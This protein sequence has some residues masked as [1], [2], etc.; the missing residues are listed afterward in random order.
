MSIK[1]E[2]A[3]KLEQ[4]RINLPDSSNDRYIIEDYDLK[5]PFSSFLPG[6]AGLEGVPM[7]CYYTNRGQAVSSF[8]TNGKQTPFLEF[9]P[10]DQAYRDTSTLGFRTFI[11]FSN[12]DFFEAFGPRK[13]RNIL[14]RFLSIGPA[15]I[16]LTEETDLLRITVQYAILP[17]ETFPGLLRSVVFENISNS[18][19]EMEILDGPG[20]IV[21]YGINDGALKGMSTTAAAWIE[22]D[23]SN[24]EIPLFK[25]RASMEDTMKV[26]SLDGANFLLAALSSDSE[27]RL[28]KPIVDPATVF[29]SDN[30]FSDPVIFRLEGLYGVFSQ[31]QVVLGRY[32]SGF[33]GAPV[34][35]NPDESVSLQVLAGSLKDEQLPISDL[36]GFVTDGIFRR[37]VNESRE[38][39]SR[40]MTNFSMKSSNPKLDSYTR[41]TG[42]DNLLRGGFPVI[43]GK[44]KPEVFHVYSRKHGDMERDYNDFSIPPQFF[45]AGFGNFRDINQNRRMDIMLNPGIGSTGIHLFFDLLQPDGYNP[46]IVHPAKFNIN[47][48]SRSVLSAALPELKVL[49]DKPFSVGEAAKILY[50]TTSELTLNDILDNSNPEAAADFGEGYWTDHWTY[51][52]DLIEQYLRVFPDR[53]EALFFKEKNYS[54]RMS[55]VKIMPL[56]KRFRKTETGTIDYC[57]HIDDTENGI[58]YWQTKS[59]LIEKLILLA[60]VKSTNLDPDSCG[61]EME[62]GRPGWYDALNGLPMLFGSSLSESAELLRLVRIILELIKKYYDQEIYLFSP[63]LEI[64]ADT[65]NSF[66]LKE[67]YAGWLKRW[68]SKDRYREVISSREPDITIIRFSS[69]SDYFQLLNKVLEKNLDTAATKNDGIL[70]T[71]NRYI[72][73]GWSPVDNKFVIP[74]GFT[75]HTMPLFLEGAVKQFRISKD[76]EKKKLLYKKVYKSDLFDTKLGMYRLNA[77]LNMEPNEIGRAK[78]FPD[79]WLENGSIWMHMEYKYLLELL[80]AGLGELFWKEA[81]NCLVP[82]MDSE[83][84][85]RSIYENS[86]FIVSSSYPEKKLHGKG[87]IGRLSGATAEYITMWNYFLLGNNPFYFEKGKLVFSPRPTLPSRIFR[88]DGT[89]EWILFGKTKVIYKNPSFR[90]LYIIDDNIPKE[91]TIIHNEEMIRFGSFIPEKYISPLRNG[92]V[93]ELSVIF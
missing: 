71:Y 74:S 26:Q 9:R 18:E 62:A 75:S 30:S 44:K 56:T 37:K 90:D 4:N 78:A 84:Y 12:G 77:S 51:N 40:L 15:D 60:V 42:L 43:A 63:L 67:K 8:G 80:K 48:S 2:T 91:I 72:P 7:W 88:E 83:V 59:S 86:S 19:I 61:L 33:A 25:I 58:E 22:T 13:D 32:P 70:P 69:L 36:P 16:I 21:P 53:E 11:R 17:S 46:L 10:A 93:K 87:L 34:K 1:I 82:F 29:G 79:G 57:P 85:S 27:T 6:I 39:I 73:T 41:Q 68:E 20:R 5:E 81:E 38:I 89:I 24:P 45:S 76:L 52:L 28:L 65:F 14:K 23:I 3:V 50:S 31:N 64:I 92:E 66:Q 55:S 35:L 54:W 47:T 49:F